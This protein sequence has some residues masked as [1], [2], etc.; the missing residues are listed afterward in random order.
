MKGQIEAAHLE[1]ADLERQKSE[2]AEKIRKLHDESA[3]LLELLTKD[4]VP[5]GKSD[6]EL[7]EVLDALKEPDVEENG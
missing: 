1:I 6:M 3:A 2:E 7:G 4:A 5:C